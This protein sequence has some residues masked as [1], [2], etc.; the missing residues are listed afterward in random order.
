[1]TVVREAPTSASSAKKTRNAT[2]LHSTPRTATETHADARTSPRR[3]PGD[4][5]ANGAYARADRPI[6]TAET[7][8]LGRCASRSDATRGPVA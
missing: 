8:R 2:A 5:R 4:A 3:A 7:A 6:A 1:M